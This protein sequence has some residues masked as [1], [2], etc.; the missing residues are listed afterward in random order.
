MLPP[1]T[2]VAGFRA[3]NS[4]KNKKEL[5]KTVWVALFLT[6]IVPVH[7]QNEALEEKEMFLAA[8]NSRPANGGD[9]SDAYAPS[10]YNSQK[11]GITA[12]NYVEDRRG[13]T[14]DSIPQP[15]P[16]YG[17]MA[18]FNREYN[19]ATDYDYNRAAV[20]TS[21]SSATLTEP[22][23]LGMLSDEGKAI[24]FSLDPEAKGLAIQVASQDSYRDKNLAVRE[25]QRRMSE[26]RGL[27]NR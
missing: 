7:G 6:P 21:I 14:Y 22:Q 3:V 16:E 9:V 12:P 19:T 2:E 23:L 17:G 26:R 11:S 1:A 25:V 4:M 5:A 27:L 10:G 24:Y 8:T 15:P 13:V 18:S 20:T